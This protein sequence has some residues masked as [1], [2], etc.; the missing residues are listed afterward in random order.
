MQRDR[1]VALP[2]PLEVVALEDA[3]QRRLRRQPDHPLGAE[4][5]E[6]LAVEHDL[7]LDRIEDLE[8]L[9]LVGLGV[10]QDLVRRQRRP[11]GLLAG[12]VADHPREIAD[13]EDDPVPELLEV[14]HL[15]H[16][17]GVAEVDV[18]SG[19]IEADLDRERLPARELRLQV[20]ALDEIDRALGEEGQLFVEIHGI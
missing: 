12:R 14:L 8:D 20:V 3:R 13:E 6:P 10:L 17:H 7:G 11:R 4:R 16:D 1:L 2:P 5:P 15:P 9:L 18:G 19:R